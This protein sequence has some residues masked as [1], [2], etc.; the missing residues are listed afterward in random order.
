M[1]NRELA[2][3][4]AALRHFQASSRD[5]PALSDGDHFHEFTPLSADEIDDLC[6]RLNTPKKVP[7][8]RKLR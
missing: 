4:L 6:E 7:I 1:T 2:T 3:I 8:K 5:V